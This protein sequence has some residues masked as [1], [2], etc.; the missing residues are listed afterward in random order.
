ML[1]YDCDRN[2]SHRF[3]VVLFHLS[4]ASSM[5][6][7]QQSLPAA[8]AAVEGVRFSEVG[9]QLVFVDL[10]RTTSSSSSSSPAP[11]PWSADESILGVRYLSMPQ[12]GEQEQNPIVTSVKL[13]VNPA[14]A[15]RA[16]SQVQ[17][18]GAGA[19]TEASVEVSS[20]SPRTVTLIVGTASGRTLFWDIDPASVAL[21]A[22]GST[23]LL[24]WTASVS[25]SSSG[26]V[27]VAS[28]AAAISTVHIKSRTVNVP[29]YT[30]VSVFADI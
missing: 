11:V 8:V 17:S 19:G 12:E 21:S 16:G 29:A 14:P 30:I 3:I 18:A 26:S 15:R 23:T 25:G 13:V 5:L 9:L 1:S 10:M 7:G 27:A 2:C 24:P 6:E 28:V 22:K 4:V 20:A